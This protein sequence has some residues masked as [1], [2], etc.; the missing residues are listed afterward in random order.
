MSRLWYTKGRPKMSTKVISAK[1]SD[2]EYDKL[3]QSCNK[4]GCTVSQFVKDACTD[5]MNTGE[6]KESQKPQDDISKFEDKITKL[7]FELDAANLII[8][9]QKQKLDAANSTIQEKIRTIK[10]YSEFVDPI[11]FNYWKSKR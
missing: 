11:S 4:K 2:E 7:Q 5:Y 9:D 8:T 10:E 6:F 1:V 3:L